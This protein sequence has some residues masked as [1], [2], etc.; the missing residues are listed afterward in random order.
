MLKKN[1][2]DNACAI[3]RVDFNKNSFGISSSIYTNESI[4]FPG[5]YFYF[6]YYFNYNSIED[7]YD[8]INAVLKEKSSF[9]ADYIKLKELEKIVKY[10]NEDISRCKWVLTGEE[11]SEVY[12]KIFEKLKSMVAV[13]I[14]F[15]KANKLEKDGE[16][17]V[18]AIQDLLNKEDPP[19]CNIL[20]HY[21]WNSRFSFRIGACIRSRYP[22]VEILTKH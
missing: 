4:S 14:E 8:R 11:W 6:D 19:I 16:D 13:L 2:N 15:E 17:N 20:C 5:D 21:K 18:Q 12:E 22:R 10:I 9:I 1:E 7:V 3:I